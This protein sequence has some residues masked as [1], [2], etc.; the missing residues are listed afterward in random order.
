M[1]T[2]PQIVASVVALATFVALAAGSVPKLGLNRATL[3]L[4]GAAVLLALGVVT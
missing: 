1:F 3:S 4:V 2:L